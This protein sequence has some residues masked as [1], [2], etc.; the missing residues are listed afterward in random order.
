MAAVATHVGPKRKRI[1]KSKKKSWKNID[2]SKVEEF[3]E[4]ERLQERTG[5][6]VADKKDEQL[7]FVDKEIE[8]PDKEPVPQKRKRSSNYLKCYANL[9]LD[10]LIKPARIAH[11]IKKRTVSPKVLEQLG[12]K[13]KSVAKLTAKK[14]RI[15]ARREKIKRIKT[16]NILPRAKYDLWS[17]SCQSTNQPE[18]IDYFLVVT[19]KK[20][21]KVPPKYKKPTSELPAVE[22]PHPGASYNPAFDDYQDLLLK[23]E[24]V[25]KKKL[26]AE[27]KLYNALEGKFPLLKD[28]PTEKTWLEEMSAGLHD[29]KAGE[30][31]ENVDT[32]LDKISVN[33]PVRREDFKTKK[34]KRKAREQKHE[35]KIATKL[36]TKKKVENEI[37]RVKSIKKEIH[38]QE[39][40][41]EKRATKKEELKEKS[42]YLPKRIGKHKF[43]EPELELKLTDELRGSLRLL[44]PEGHLLEDR[45]KS[46][47]KRNIIE[48]R[49]RAKRKNT[50]K[51]K[52][53]EKKTH[54][55]ITL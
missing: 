13:V 16:R 36:K 27:R 18:E 30:E 29:E 25:E 49:I 53:L 40:V 23:A 43:E 54:K 44:S 46:L 5:G 41:Y 15:E 1:A 42:K 7:F 20:R 2:V 9:E 55:E 51:P 39:T 6:L 33:P 26:K 19:K 52:V 22:V 14:Q 34:Q 32:D 21:V 12:K 11:N 28:T 24:E 8:E 4:D 50:Y 3:L 38:K 35:L 45:F 48:P 10:P 37:F 31:D 47:Q 17:D